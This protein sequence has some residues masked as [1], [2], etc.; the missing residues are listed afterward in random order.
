MRCDREFWVAFHDP[1]LQV[2]GFRSSLLKTPQIQR[3]SIAASISRVI[4]SAFVICIAPSPTSAYDRP[5]GCATGGDRVR[6]RRAHR[7]SPPDSEHIMPRR[8]FRSRAYQFA[9]E[10]E[11]LV[12]IARSGRRGDNSQA[13]RCAGDRLGRLHRP[14][15]QRFPPAARPASML[16]R[17][18]WSDF[19]CKNGTGRESF[20]SVAGEVDIHWIPQAQHLWRDIDSALPEPAFLGRNSEY[21]NLSRSSAKRVA[22]GHQSLAR[23]GAEQPD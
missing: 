8:I 3:V 13:T 4:S 2:T 16:L 7:A 1:L 15:F 11:S 14:V 6:H 9:Q 18:L 5:V 17:Q 10:P 23:F 12:M 19:S 21:G 20:G 22:L